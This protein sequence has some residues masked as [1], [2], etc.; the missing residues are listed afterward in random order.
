LKSTKNPRRDRGRA[1]KKEA[2]EAAQA[3]LCKNRGKGLFYLTD[4]LPLSRVK[5]KKRRVTAFSDFGK[6]EKAVPLSPPKV[7]PKETT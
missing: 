5:K 7:P 3:V 1:I 6:E 2:P 4:H